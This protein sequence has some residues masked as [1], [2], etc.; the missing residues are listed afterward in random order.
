M[1][2]HGDGSNGRKNWPS[3]TFDSTATSIILWGEIFLPFQSLQIDGSASHYIIPSLQLD[4]GWFIFSSVSK[5]LSSITPNDMPLSETGHF[6][7]YLIASYFA[8]LFSL[9]HPW[10]VEGCISIKSLRY[11][12]NPRGKR[13]EILELNSLRQFLFLSSQALKVESGY[14]CL[15]IAIFLISIIPLCYTFAWCFS[16]NAG[17]KEASGVRDIVQAR[18]ALPGELSSQ[19][20]A[21]RKLLKYHC[22]KRFFVFVLQF[23]ILTCMWDISMTFYGMDIL[24]DDIAMTWGGRHIY[25]VKDIGWPFNIF[26]AHE[27]SFMKS[28]FHIKIFYLEFPSSQCSS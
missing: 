2:E 12:N 16:R 3:L 21:K 15:I 4:D 5:F 22:R 20:N 8:Y 18:L 9:L 19:D 10:A 17:M 14:I 13:K 11:P 27:W 23:F 7:C 26:F 25:G 6:S 28:Q 1:N 24:A